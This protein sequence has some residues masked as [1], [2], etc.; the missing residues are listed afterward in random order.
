MRSLITFIDFNSANSRLALNP[1]KRLAQEVGVAIDWRPLS[2][3]P[4]P[5]RQ[6][7]PQPKGARHARIRNEY[8]Q[9]EHAFYAEQQGIRL[10]YPDPGRG[11]FTANAGLAWLKR[12][13]QASSSHSDAY[14]QL[15]F[16]QV[17]NGAMDPQDHAAVAKAIAAA[18]GDT[19]G[20]NAYLNEQAEADL[21]NHRRRALDWGAM[22]VPAYIVDGEP[23]IGRAHLPV[24]RSLL[25]GRND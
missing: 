8:L 11:S 20:F 3:M 22:E 19:E 4:K 17:W 1:T 24:I 18:G 21:T 16:E 23:F 14:V 9:R 15:V 2:R 5:Q 10:V 12:Q 13:G 6:A 25:T 7:D